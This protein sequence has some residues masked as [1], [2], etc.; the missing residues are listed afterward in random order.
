MKHRFFRLLAIFCI[1]FPVQAAQAGGLASK[2]RD[3]AKK[4]P[5]RTAQW[6][7][8]VKDAG[9]GKTLVDWDSDKS[10][11][12][13]ST[14]KLF[15]TAAALSSLGPE[16]R[17]S[18]LLRHDGAVSA[19]VLK[20]NLVIRGG[21]DPS[22]GSTLVRGGRPMEA[23][24]ADWLKAL[25]DKG[26]KAVQGD[27]VGDNTLF[28]GPPIPGSWPW[29]DA[30]NYYAAPADAL[31]IND[32][33]YHLYFA[34]GP[35]VG[36][37]AEVLRM[38]P[39]IPGLKFVN[40]MKT[41][42]EDSG[43]N[44]YVYNIPAGYHA[45]LRGT[46]P[47]GRKEFAIKGAIPEPALFAAQA[48]A[49]FLR[50]SAI[51]V[52]GQAR[53]LRKPVSYD[54][55]KVLCRT[56]SVPLRDIVRLTNKRSFNLYAEMLSRAV[57]LR[58][59]RPASVEG[60]NLAV[61]EHLRS[62]GIDMAGVRIEDACG[63]SRLDLVTARA[64]TDALVFMAKSRF[65]ADYHESLAFPGD[66]EGFGHIK[67]FGRGTELEKSL[68]IKSGSLSGV[69][70]YSGY[71]RNKAGRLL[72]FTFIVNNYAASPAEIEKIHEELLLALAQGRGG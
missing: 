8:C 68:R 40:F 6:G 25:S 5:L 16:F 15:V 4:A 58:T 66:P 9:T 35:G 67:S 26:I 69:R 54:E 48:F 22:L 63:L 34:P 44:G 50:K 61:R 65:F 43:D 10:L 23:V 60:A 64:M 37:D 3:L 20:G 27:V 55:E 51:K 52:V 19:G 21:G 11:V 30:G 59:G 49:G 1:S 56:P 72:A 45:V 13:G 17:F 32:N 29:E 38:E 70:S 31:T 14:L 7:V 12:P 28:E 47:A 62:A 2:V 39:E 42:P 24:F 46:L 36:A 18:T 53:L 71:L 57:A 41:G 33:L